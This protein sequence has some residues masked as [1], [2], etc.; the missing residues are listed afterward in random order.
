MDSL[1]KRRNG[2]LLVRIMGLLRM[3]WLTMGW[4]IPRMDGR[5]PMTSKGGHM[6][7]IRRVSMER[8]FS[9]IMTAIFRKGQTPELMA[10]GVGCVRRVFGFG[11]RIDW[12]GD[13]GGCE[14][15]DENEL[16]GNSE[17]SSKC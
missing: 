14:G 3:D 15:S 4:L 8:V 10:S 11:R 5:R 16:H 13:G 12:G 7:L 17:T 6:H 9:A 2:R 1:Q